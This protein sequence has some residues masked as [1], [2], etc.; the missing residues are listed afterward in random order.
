MKILKLSVLLSVAGAIFAG[1]MLFM[2]SQKVQQKEDV[3]AALERSS[4]QE[5]AHIRVLRAEWDYLNRPDRLERLVSDHMGMDVP[6]STHLLQDADHVPEP[7][8]VAPPSR[9]PQFF[10]QPVSTSSGGAQ[11]TPKEKPLP[12]REEDN[13]S[14]LLG[15]LKKGGADE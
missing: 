11:V 3:L 5:A 14:K 6:E 12:V 8:M 4:K 2:T 1:A 15:K 13:F 7:R 10:A 9:K